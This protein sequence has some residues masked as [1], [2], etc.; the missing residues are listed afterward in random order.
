MPSLG[1]QAVSDQGLPPLT[2]L[3]VEFRLVTLTESKWCHARKQNSKLLIDL[4][5]CYGDLKLPGKFRIA[6]THGSGHPNQGAGGIQGDGF[7]T[8]TGFQCRQEPK[9]V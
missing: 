1:P 5:C 8:G 9:Q 3:A 7:Y 4:L 6:F 2:F